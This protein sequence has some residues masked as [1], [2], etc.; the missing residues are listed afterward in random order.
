MSLKVTNLEHT[1]NVIDGGNFLED[2]FTITAKTVNRP[3]I[4]INSQTII[5]HIKN[6]L[7]HNPDKLSAV[8][9]ALLFLFDNPQQDKLI[10]ALAYWATEFTDFNSTQTVDELVA[11]LM[12]KT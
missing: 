6:V 5:N 7:E 2:T 11:I 8:A 3:F 12:D 10:E 1:R 4:R 9:S